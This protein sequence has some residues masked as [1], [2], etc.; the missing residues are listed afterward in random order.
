MWLV[1]YH[2]ESADQSNSYN[3]N[4]VLLWVLKL[5]SAPHSVTSMVGGNG[6]CILKSVNDLEF[7]L[8]L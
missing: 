2:Y 1:S 7:A 6:S 4:T 5:S 3:T 8:A